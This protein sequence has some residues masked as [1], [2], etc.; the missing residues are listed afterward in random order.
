MNE[1]FLAFVPIFVAVDAI[2]LL[3]IYLNLTEG[4]APAARR[5]IVFQSFLTAV[6]VAVGFVFLAKAVFR[7]MGI[8][9]QDFMVAGGVLLFAI[10]AMDLVSE[11]K[12]TR[13]I[14][15]LGA[16][17]LG[18]PLIVGPAVLTTAL[19]L[20]DVYGLVPTLLSVVV[21]VFIAC[22]IFCGATAIEKVLGHAG[23]KAVSKV[24]G[25]ILA[26]IAVMMIRKG[27]VGILAT[28]ATGK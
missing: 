2:G 13:H 20:V 23:S 25:L 11:R 10:S 26:A 8:T 16:V 17:P 22:A 21:N 7:L 18:T 27:L 4:L 14:D 3:P 28:A 19:M 12:F 1:F 24:A 5:K 15:T 9:I 6:L